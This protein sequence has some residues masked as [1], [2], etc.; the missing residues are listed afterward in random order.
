MFL[1]GVGIIILILA[2]FVIRIW[3]KSFSDS[4]ENIGL[5]E[6]KIFATLNGFANG[7]IST[8]RKFCNF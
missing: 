3:R 7:F 8:V 4:V 2:F 5:S 1:S 6:P